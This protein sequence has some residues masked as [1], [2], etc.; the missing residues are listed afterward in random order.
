MRDRIIIEKDLIPYTFEIVL[1][2]ENFEFSI[3]YNET[4]DLFTISLYKDDI[5]IVTEPIIYNQPLFGDVYM[6]DK[7]PV[8]V[9]VPIDESGQETEVT[10]E[11]F[12]SSV[13]LCIDDTEESIV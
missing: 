12:G 3:D 9:I 6:V 1:G 11:N 13:F 8:I 10:R 4:A 7:Y 5:L 2:N